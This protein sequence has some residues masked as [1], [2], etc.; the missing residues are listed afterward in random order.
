MKFT[1]ATCLFALLAASAPAQDRAHLLGK[2]DP[3]RDPTF[4]KI[5]AP[6]SDKADMYLQKDAAAAFRNMAD[7]ARRAGISLKIISATR[8]FAQQKSIWEGKWKRF[9]KAAPAPLAR[10]R[11]ILEYSAMPGTSRHHWGTDVDLNDLN[12]PAF[13][14]GGKQEK[15]YLWLVAHAHEYGFCQPYTA[16]RAHGYN[17]EKW[18]WSYLPVAGPYLKTYL[19]TIGNEVITGFQGA[20]L[21][22]KLDAVG[23]YAGGVNGDC[24]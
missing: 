23:K 20:E 17:E 8:T 1:L 3:A 15:V 9:A 13:E 6:Y 22:G 21:A 11:K 16:G 18:H 14:R 5:A 12:N 2:I 24:R 10:A 4:V 7:A 19:Q